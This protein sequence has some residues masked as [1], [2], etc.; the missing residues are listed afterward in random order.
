[1]FKNTASVI[2]LSAGLGLALMNAAPSWAQDAQT[3][4]V[5]E[6]PAAGQEQGTTTTTTEGVTTTEP[7]AGQEPATTTT[8]TEEVTTTQPAE[9]AAPAAVEGQETAEGEQA[10]GQP[11]PGQIFEQS[12]NQFLGST[13]MDA[14]V[15]SADGEQ[16]GGVTDIIVTPD[17][18]V[19]GVVLGVGG[20]LGI[21]QKDVAVQM[22]QITIRQEEQGDPDD[23]IFVLNATREQLENAP[24]FRTQAEEAAEEAAQDPAAAG[25]ATVDPAA[26]G[27]MTTDPAAGGAMTDPAAGG[28]TTDPAAGAATTDPAAGGATTTTTPEQPAAGQ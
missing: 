17:G 3:P 23:L 6:Q 14:E 15:Q 27:A 21:G 26:G 12:A 8:T 7:A 25:G 11:V 4:A 13:L 16:I 20:F 5:P 1:M 9:G 28:A 24:E 10:E 22:N 18:R 2:A 19:D